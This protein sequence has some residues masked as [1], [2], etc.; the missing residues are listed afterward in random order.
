VANKKLTF[1]QLSKATP[2]QLA[3]LRKDKENEYAEVLQKS[4]Q[5]IAAI[6]WFQKQIDEAGGVK[7]DD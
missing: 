3:Q 6:L 7:S 4:W 5:D 1:E 2:N